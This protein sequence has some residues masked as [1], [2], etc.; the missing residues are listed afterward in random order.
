MR[1]HTCGAVAIAGWLLMSPPLVKDEKAPGGYRPDRNA[2]VPDWHQVSAH[3]TAS[4]CER[5]KSEAAVNAMTTAKSGSRKDIGE[6][7]VVQAALASLCV[8]AD[9]I[10]FPSDEGEP[11]AT[12]NSL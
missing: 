8:P 9:Y 6:D 7:P 5:A 3:D 10:Y 1:K 4:D 11:S 2:K 12:G